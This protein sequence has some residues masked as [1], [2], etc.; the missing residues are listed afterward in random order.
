M[1]CA[2]AGRCFFVEARKEEDSPDELHDIDTFVY[3]PEH[4]FEITKKKSL[5]N[6]WLPHDPSRCITILDSLNNQS[7]SLFEFLSAKRVDRAVRSGALT[8]FNVGHVSARAEEFHTDK[9]IYPYKY[10]AAKI[11]WSMHQP[12]RRTVYV[13]E[14]FADSDFEWID[15]AEMEYI[16]ESLCK[17]WKT[18][19]YHR[20]QQM[21]GPSEVDDYTCED[22]MSRGLGSHFQPVFRVVAM[23]NPTRPIFA[24]SL[25]DIHEIIMKNV[26]KCFSQY[27]SK[28]GFAH[29]MRL[30]RSGE[31]PFGVSPHQFFGIGLPVV[32][33]AIE[34]MPASV[35]A[36]L[37]SRQDKWRY[38]PSYRLPNAE[39]VA[40]A[41]QLQINQTN[42]LST[43]LNGSARADA[44]V[45]RES[46]P[47]GKKITR[48]LT[49]AADE[50]P[51]EVLFSAPPGMTGDDEQDEAARVKQLEE[52]ERRV[53]LQLDEIALREKYI[54]MS[55]SYLVDPYARLEV[56]KSR[57]H[58]WG[59]FA[60][61][62]F[63]RN[64][65]VIEYIGEKI[66]Q[67]MADRREEKYELDGVG[68]CYLFRY[69]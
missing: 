28:H 67:A 59:L 5:R 38:R 54:L 43:S 66:R 50:D 58:G 26:E 57:I 32:R 34:S 44:Y 56:K 30:G 46:R 35:N 4:Q 22:F 16:N 3:C 65:V 7:D 53:S 51:S 23:D 25:E 21:E 39:D 6:G 47:T 36:M 12:M 68:S 10:K 64:D 69:C 49:K 60:R 41:H 31:Y 40:R 15:A 13:L 8:V 20:R 42:D 48:I 33:L 27:Y 24:R 17:H 45:G 9:F 37:F 29:T 61:I 19:K 52:E 2:Y 62:S 18:P 55:K 1:P 63:E 11:Y 14:I